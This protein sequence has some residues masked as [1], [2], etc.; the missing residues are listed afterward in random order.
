MELGIILAKLANLGKLSIMSEKK[1]EAGSLI[2]SHKQIKINY[3]ASDSFQVP[4]HLPSLPDYS[5]SYFCSRV[6]V[7]SQ[8]ARDRYWG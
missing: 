1:A 2:Q 6:R 3:F 8:T 5:F 4:C 7:R